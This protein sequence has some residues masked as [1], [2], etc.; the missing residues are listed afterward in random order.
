MWLTRSIDHIQIVV[1]SKPKKIF[2]DEG[3]DV[4]TIIS[5][6]SGTSFP[7]LATPLNVQIYEVIQSNSKNAKF[8]L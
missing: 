4:R 6:C 2:F 8:A 7:T 3:F 5:Q 1:Q